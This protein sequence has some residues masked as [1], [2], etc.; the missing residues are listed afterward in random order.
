[1]SEQDERLGQVRAWI[2]EQV[3]SDPGLRD[4]S[5]REDAVRRLRDGVADRFYPDLMVWTAEEDIVERLVMYAVVHG[6]DDRSTA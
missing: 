3:R 6:P 5:G 1:M 4:E 2:D